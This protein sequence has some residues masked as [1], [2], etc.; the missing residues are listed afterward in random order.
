MR[1]YS[2]QWCS[3]SNPHAKDKIMFN[4]F[5]LFNKKKTVV[6]NLASNVKLTVVPAVAGGARATLEEMGDIFTRREQAYF[7]TLEELTNSLQLSDNVIIG[8]LSKAF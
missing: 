3:E 2:K 7:A 1:N 4:M 6:V 8:K 5:N